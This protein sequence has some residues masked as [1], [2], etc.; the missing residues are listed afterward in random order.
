MR[1]DYAVPQQRF[2]VNDDRAWLYVPDEKTVFLYD[3]EEIVQSPLLLNFF[4]G[5]TQLAKAFRIT[6]LPAQPESPDCRRLELLP[7]DPVSAVARVLLWVDSSSHQIVRIQTEDPLGNINDIAL[8]HIE[9][10]PELEASL[11]ELKVP[12]GVRVV[13]QQPVAP[14]AP[15]AQSLGTAEPQNLRGQDGARGRGGDNSA[16]SPSTGSGQASSGQ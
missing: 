12:E 2:V 9:L 7:R 3:L 4:S 13:R 14:A 6:Q 16:G 15:E 10:N 8:E 1:W 11:F 5:M